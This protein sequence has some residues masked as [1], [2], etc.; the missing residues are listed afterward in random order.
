MLDAK[1]LD[2]PMSTS[3]RIYN[4]EEFKKVN[5]TM[6]RGINGS[7]LYFIASTPYIVFSVGMCA[8][9]QAALKE[10]HLKYA[11][12]FLQYLK[13]THDMVLFYQTCDSFI[14]FGYA[15]ED[16]A[17]FLEDRK[18]TSRMTRFLGSDLISW[19]MKKQNSVSLSTTEVEYFVAAACCT[20]LL[21]I[22]QQLNDFGVLTKTIPLLRDNTSV[23]N[24][25]KNPIQHKRTK[26]IDDRHHFL[27]G[28][29]EKMNMLMR[30]CNTE[31]KRADIFTKPLEKKSFFKID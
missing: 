24:M 14:L 4:D 8:R 12:R 6:Y 3:A 26:H 10:L 28:N 17:D 29:V 18:S 27:R 30:F 2:T 31:D 13:G 19:G 1:V 5:Q 21:R 7:L 20:H 11:K 22:K 15:D 23:M 16:Y 25:S 9:V